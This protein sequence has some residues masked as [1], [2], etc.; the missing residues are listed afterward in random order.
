MLGLADEVVRIEPYTA[1]WAALFEAERQQ[2]AAAIGAHVLDIQ[3]IGST[4]IPGMSAKP[5]LDIGVAVNN[6]EAAA[7]C[8]GPLEA[9]G[10]RYRGEFGIPRRHYFVKGEPCTHH[11]HMVEL[12]SDDWRQ[13]IAFRDYL[14]DH[15]ESARIYAEL[16]QR[17]AQQFTHDRAAYQAGKN[18]LI[19]QIIRLSGATPTD[20]QR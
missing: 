7:V 5:I 8:I 19:Q 15:P 20:A 10:Y 13:T 18:S 14:I 12:H 11:L 2:I 1:E 9:L 3:H 16:K 17:L 6:F 4:A